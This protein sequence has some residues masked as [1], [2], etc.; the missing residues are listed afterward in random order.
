MCCV[1]LAH[2]AMLRNGAST[3]TIFRVFVRHFLE[4]ELFH[5][6][7]TDEIRHYIRHKT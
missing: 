3:P 7:F 5:V 1:A 4:T 6:G 2:L